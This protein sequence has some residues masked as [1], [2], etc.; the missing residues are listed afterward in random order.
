MGK[1]LQPED[2]MGS[3]KKQSSITQ[4]AANWSRSSFFLD[5]FLYR[6]GNAT[7]DVSSDTE[8]R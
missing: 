6:Q 3:R 1:W 2:D 7:W 8:T 4:A 5:T